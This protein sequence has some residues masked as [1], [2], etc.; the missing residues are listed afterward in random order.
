MESS[1]PLILNLEFKDKQYSYENAK[2]VKN[3]LAKEIQNMM[4]FPV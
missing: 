2:K 1:W 3:I 4:C